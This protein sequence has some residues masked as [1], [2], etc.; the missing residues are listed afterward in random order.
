MSIIEKNA[1]VAQNKDEEHNR[2]ILGLPKSY[3]DKK[4][5]SQGFSFEALAEYL[6]KLHILTDKNKGKM[7]MSGN[8]IDNNASKEIANVKD[9][10]IVTADIDN[11]D[12]MPDDPQHYS[13]DEACKDLDVFGYNAIIETTYSHK[14][15]EYNF[16]DKFRIQIPMLEPYTFDGDRDKDKEFWEQ[17]LHGQIVIDAI[18]KRPDAMD[19]S[20]GE[21][22]RAFYLHSC[23]A[24]RKK[25]ARSRVF[26][27]GKFVDAKEYV[28]DAINQKIQALSEI[29]ETK[30]VFN[31]IDLVKWDNLYGSTFDIW[32]AI[33]NT[34]S[35]AIGNTVDKGKARTLTECPFIDE[36]ESNQ[37]K[38]KTVV[39]RPDG[40]GSKFGFNCQGEGCTFSGGT[41]R[42]RLE[43]LQK[44]LEDGTITEAQIFTPALGGWKT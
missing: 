7:F 26:N 34:N 28:Q 43:Y 32:K 40:E 17:R 38:T 3:Q 10:Q 25:H 23:P 4:I 1:P 6:T 16:V 44:M 29:E 8:V 35:K 2:F 11:K 41:H 31:E 14:A 9:V 20:S 18:G 22:A 12:L 30:Y 42:P 27:T 37:G 21:I 33:E 19:K 36:H 15:P 39:Y 13:Y 5:K 24:D